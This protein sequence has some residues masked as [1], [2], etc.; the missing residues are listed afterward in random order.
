[1]VIG[2]EKR[3]RKPIIGWTSSNI[4]VWTAAGWLEIERTRLVGEFVQF[5][6]TKNLRDDDAT[7][8]S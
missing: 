7:Q 3:R 2:L 5:G 1:M 6:V 8:A 4:F